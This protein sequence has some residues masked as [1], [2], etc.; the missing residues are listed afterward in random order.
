MPV[1]N[2][3][4]SFDP[5]QQQLR[6]D[7]TFGF[8]CSDNPRTNLVD[9]PELALAAHA[10]RHFVFFSPNQATLSFSS[11]AKAEQVSETDGLPVHSHAVPLV[12][13]L[14]RD[15]G[16]SAIQDHC[17]FFLI[18]FNSRT[19]VFHGQ[20]YSGLKYVHGWDTKITTTTDEALFVSGIIAGYR[21]DRPSN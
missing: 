21:G 6:M 13:G 17:G 8:F 11:K 18:G 10:R 1:S 5:E 19:S 12:N 16:C 3:T 14:H 20:G 2:H 15:P 9:A 7:D 4:S